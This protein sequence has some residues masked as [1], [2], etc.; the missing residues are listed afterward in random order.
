MKIGRIWW[1]SVEIKLLG[2]RNGVS[3][4]KKG[5]AISIEII[6]IGSREAIGGERYACIKKEIFS[7]RAKGFSESLLTK[8]YELYGME[9]VVG[10]DYSIQGIVLWK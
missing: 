2:Y 4:S 5:W 3:A 1:T 9:K 10:E 7:Q 8:R 6:L